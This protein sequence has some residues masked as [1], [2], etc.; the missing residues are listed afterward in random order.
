MSHT[1]IGLNTQRV[2]GILTR[3]AF[4]FHMTAC[5]MRVS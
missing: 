2:Y 5:I 3:R 1:L 4:F